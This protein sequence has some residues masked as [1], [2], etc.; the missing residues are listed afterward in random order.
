MQKTE[1]CKE[2]VRISIPEVGLDARKGSCTKMACRVI[3]VMY[4]L[5]CRKINNL[6]N[7]TKNK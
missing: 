3:T 5:R 2:N 6:T 7:M 1:K 4:K